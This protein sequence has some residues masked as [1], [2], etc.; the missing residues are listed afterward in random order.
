[1]A[2]V[3]IFTL[4]LSPD[5]NKRTTGEQ[6][7]SVSLPVVVEVDNVHKRYCA[8]LLIDGKPDRTL[9]GEYLVGDSWSGD[10]EQQQQNAIDDL[11]RKILKRLKQ[12]SER[13][14]S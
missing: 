4:D 13:A 11:R 10:P 3:K 5:A 1:M 9:Y 8:C 6:N 7:R 14:G 12:T 2:D